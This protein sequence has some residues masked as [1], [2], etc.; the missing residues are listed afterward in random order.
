MVF[1]CYVKWYFLGIM[2]SLITLTLL[3]V[4]CFMC[5][6]LFYAYKCY[7]CLPMSALGLWEWLMILI[8]FA[9]LTYLMYYYGIGL[10][11]SITM[12]F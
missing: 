5:L 6:I 3:S 12:A 8:L 1:I 2:L 4:Y 11:D 9:Q 10:W 7:I